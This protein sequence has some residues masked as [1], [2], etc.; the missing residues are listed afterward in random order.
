MQK[1]KIDELLARVHKQATA[2]E[3]VRAIIPKRQEIQNIPDDDDDGDEYTP[4]GVKG[5]I[6]ASQKLLAINR[7]LDNTDERDS[8]QFKR[9]MTTDRLLAEGVKL[10]SG[11]V[12]GSIIPLIAK[13]RNLKAVGPFAFD[14]YMEKFLTGNSLSSP[15]EEINPL[16]LLEQARRSTQMGQGGIGTEQA[17]TEGM[18]CHDAETEVFTRD[19]WK[20]WP[21]VTKD[22]YL[23]CRVNEVMEFHKPTALTAQYYSGLM[24]GVKSRSVNFLVTPNHRF[25]TSS[26][27]RTN[28]WIWETAEEH[29]GKYRVYTSYAAPYSGTDFSDTFTLP[30]AVISSTGDKPRIVPP[31]DMGDWCEFLG[32]FMSEGS[33]YHN[34]KSNSGG[35]SVIISQC[36]I[37]NPSKVALIDSLCSRLPFH[38]KWHVK[39]C[40]ISSKALYTY[41]Q[42]YGKVH[43][44]YVPEFIFELKP[45]YRQRFLDAFLLGDGHKTKFGNKLYSSCSKQLAI[46]IQRLVTL[47]GKAVSWGNPWMAKKRNGEDS[48]TMYRVSELSRTKREIKAVSHY[49]HA[50]FKGM[51]YC[52]TVPGSLLLTRRGGVSFWSGNSINTDQF[53]FLSPLEGPESEKIGIDSR[54]A[55]GSKIGSNGRPYQRFF[56]RRSGKFR[57]MSPEDL[58]GLTVKL[59]D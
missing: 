33:I 31:M 23:A 42:V 4:V 27:H 6:S 45:E 39:N 41:L 47:A 8:M 38:H 20:M 19:G 2:Q 37:A 11:R 55:Y 51:V 54:H 9:I 40:I 44:K 57:W 32:W 56:D 26:S 28:K 16:H 35:Y 15:L 3:K 36:D 24:Y 50:E 53:G 49:K 7:G 17:I 58:D 14:S 1:S 13:H 48:S 22:D 10:D 25:F 43:D 52:A 12:R 34:Y 46:G 18:Q 30:P 29:F 5:L 21:D 59:P